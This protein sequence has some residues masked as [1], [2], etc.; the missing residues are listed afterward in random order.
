M[1]PSSNKD[2]E[3]DEVNKALA[4]AADKRLPERIASLCQDESHCLTRVPGKGEVKP[5]S[6][7]PNEKP[8]TA[9][10][11]TAGG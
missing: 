5:R 2:K 8:R 11:R 9:G 6:L 7:D 1:A 10:A 4:A 3:K